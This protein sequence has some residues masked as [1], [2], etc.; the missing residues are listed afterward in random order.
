MPFV[1]VKKK[2]QVVI[3]V[4]IR[5]QLGIEVGDLLEVKVDR[6]RITLTPKMVIDRRTAE[7]LEETSEAMSATL[8]VEPK[9]RPA[10]I[11]RIEKLR[12]RKVAR[13]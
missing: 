9:K 1:T 3:P 10:S 6:G 5:R 2:F 12:A 8:R 7:N 13:P 4:A 11:Q